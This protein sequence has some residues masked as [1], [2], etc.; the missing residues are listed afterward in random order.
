MNSRHMHYLRK[1][2]K[3]I[4]VFMG[5]VCMITFV[6]GTALFDLV[7]SRGA[8]AQ[9]QNPVVV[10]WVKGKVHEDELNRMR[11][12]HEVAYVFLSRVVQEA[13]SRGG[14]PIIN[15]RP[16]TLEQM[17]DVGI[18]RDSSDEA[19]MQTMILA[20]EARRLGVVVDFEAVK[21]FLKQIS[22]PELAEADWRDIANEV[23]G[24]NLSI[25]E[26]NEQLAYELSAQHVRSM[27]RAG[28]FSQGM[29]PIVPPGEAWDMFNRLN[30]RVSIEAWPIDVQPLIAQVKS[31]PTAA[32]IEKL[33]QDGRFREPDP[34]SD[35]P[36]FRQPQKLA[37]TWLKVNFEPFLE[38]AK[39]QITEQQIEEQY[40]KD[41]SQGLHKEPEPPSTTAPG[42]AATPGDNKA[43]EPGTT[44]KPTTEKPTTEKPA[45]EAPAA[46]KPAEKP[47]GENPPAAKPTPAT[48]APAAPATEKPA[49]EKPATEKPTPA[50]SAE[51]KPAEQPECGGDEPAAP[52]AALGT[53]QPAKP[54][55]PTETT[56]ANPPPA[57][58]K[59]ADAKPSDV[60]PADTKP[61]EKPVAPPAEP[62][63]TTPAAAAPANA[64][65]AAPAAEPKFKPLE[66]VH[67]EILKKLAQ[68]IA[69]E[70]RK[71]AVAEVMG[72]IDKYGKAFRRYHDVISV[73]KTAD[74]KDPGSLD[75]VPLATKYGF[76][77]GDT[78]KR[79]GKPVAVDRFEIANFDIGQKVQQLDMQAI[80]AG[81]FRLL[82]FADLA[83]GQEHPLFQAAEAR[84]SEPDRSY[85]YFRTA[86][87]KPK[88]LTLEEAR[89]LVIEFWKKQQ[90]FGL[91]KAE[92]QKLAD[93]A[94]NAPAL[95]EAVP[96]ASKVITTP[97]FSWVTAGGMG[98]GMG[99]PELSR[100]P[101]IDL[102]GQEFMEGVFAL[103][104]SQTGVAPNQ[105]HSKVYVVRVTTQNPGDDEL[106]SRFL[107]SGYNQLV[108]SLAQGQAVYTWIDWFRELAD[109]YHVQ[110][111]RLPREDRQT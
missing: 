54:A 8:N 98:M 34:T 90:A 88:E 1:N 27:A 85:I 57:D 82:S 36:G 63:A 62:A 37:F 24:R 3:V 65:A 48:P 87:E 73:R 35:E 53:E 92:A 70:A 94:K 61:E 17:M 97:L 12:R 14:H 4:M 16:V 103:D 44:E 99:Q 52:A 64:P 71:K 107:E 45:A 83:Y 2:A 38:E 59:P 106:R 93:K 29:M 21:S 101:G 31:E 105:A 78:G 42:A 39:K 58:A 10:T 89:P 50:K 84:S 95:N 25:G 19:L 86:E 60:I 46:D 47:A 49:T 80:Q 9:V 20:E 33:Y 7:N 79:D 66:L 23:V 111:Q 91:A 5:I 41:I 96:D 15:G 56:P 18:P 108:L 69:E 77:I 76:E 72:T 68:P 51:E 102:A 13:L 74:I 40:Q 104:P 30:R 109:Q 100:V 28:L 43:G 75:I 110:W 22:S 26:L 67:D 32:E 6:V 81:Q 55:A 11:L